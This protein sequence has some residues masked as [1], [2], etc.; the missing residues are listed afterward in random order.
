MGTGMDEHERDVIA[1]MQFEIVRSPEQML[2]FT[3]NVSEGTNHLSAI[4]LK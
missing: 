3:D 1:P 4:K 2:Y